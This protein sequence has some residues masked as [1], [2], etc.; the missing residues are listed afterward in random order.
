MLFELRTYICKPGMREQWVKWSEEK[1]IPFQV[2]KGVVVVGT[3]VSNDNPDVY[4]W[5]R[6][7][8][9]EAD[10]ERA[11]KAVYEDPVWKSEI[12]PRNAELLFR[13]KIAVTNMSATPHSVIS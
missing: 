12:G 1:V 11:Y 3:F 8:A 7:F 6:R 2:S 9:D 13:E 4:I 5:I 10:K